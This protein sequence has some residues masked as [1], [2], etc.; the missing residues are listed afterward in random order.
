MEDKT[1]QSEVA[2]E[3]ATPR[4]EELDLMRLLLLNR[5]V[6]LLERDITIAQ[7]RLSD[8]RKVLAAYNSQLRDKYGI[9]E[10]DAIDSQTG[11]I[12]KNGKLQA[13]AQ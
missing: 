12:I 4:L 13:A 9:T 10:L 6:D 7:L 5:D 3:T 1:E 8:S 2:P 11:E